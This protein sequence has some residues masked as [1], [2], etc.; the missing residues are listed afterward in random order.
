M[1]NRAKS[2]Q[3]ILS[4]VLRILPSGRYYTALEIYGML[5][6]G[7]YLTPAD[8]TVNSGGTETK[9]YRRLQNALRDGANALQIQKNEDSKPFQYRVTP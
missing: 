4:I 7:G 9:S 2:G 1:G 5:N 6:D 3:D 8:L